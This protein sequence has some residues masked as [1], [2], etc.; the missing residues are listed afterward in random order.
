[1]FE[2]DVL[3]AYVLFIDPADLQRVGRVARDFLLRRNRSTAPV[4]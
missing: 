3:T 1:M 2:W 4:A